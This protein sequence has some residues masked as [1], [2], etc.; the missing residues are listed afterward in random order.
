MTLMRFLQENRWQ[1][2][3]V[4]VVQRTLNAS[5]FA[6][7]FADRCALFFR[8]EAVGADT[9]RAF[10]AENRFY[11]TAANRIC[12]GHLNGVITVEQAAESCRQNGGGGA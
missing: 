1:P 8:G 5:E 3:H 11:T 4:E 2:L 10:F 6:A 9:P 7:A 12:R